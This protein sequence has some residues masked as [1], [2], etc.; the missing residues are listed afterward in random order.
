MIIVDYKDRRPIYEQIVE[1]FQMLIVKGVMEPDSQMPSVRKLAMDLSINPNTIQKA[2]T[3]LEQQG[4]IYPVKGKGNFVTGDRNL[5][6]QKKKVAFDD[7]QTVVS[8]GKEL[9]ITR[10]EFYIKVDEVYGEV[11]YDRSNVH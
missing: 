2:Y 6:V 3:Q 5:L 10:D 8:Q 7:F 11:N 9:G 4:F 1:K